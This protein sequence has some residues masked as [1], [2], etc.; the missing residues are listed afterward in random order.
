MLL[1]KCRSTIA[2]L[3][4]QHGSTLL[5][6]K[7]LALSRLLHKSL[8]QSETVSP[9]LVSLY[10]QLSTLRRRVL[11]RL[12]QG[13][14][15]SRSTLNDVVGAICAFCLATS[16]SPSDALQHFQHL[17][18]E[19]IRN[20]MC[21]EGDVRGNTLKAFRY[22]VHSL[23]STKA[24]LGRQLSEALRGLRNQP[25]IQDQA[26]LDL[27]E[28]DLATVQR[29]VPVEIRNFVPFIKH[30]DPTQLNAE[31]VITQWS[32]KAFEQYTEALTQH[33]RSL[34]KVSEALELR[35]SILE[36][37]LPIYVS[38]PS[39]SPSEILE[40]IRRIIGDQVNSFI[41]RDAGLLSD[42][43]LN[44]ESSV[45]GGS[46][47]EATTSR[48]LWDEGFV[49][50]PLGKGGSAFKQELRRRY[51]NT[52]DKLAGLLE[53]LETWIASVQ[54]TRTV[55]NQLRNDRW[56]DLIQEDEDDDEAGAVIAEKLQKEDPD[57]W[58]EG[59]N[60]ALRDALGTLQ[61]HVQE[62]AEALK[63]KGQRTQDSVI[64]LLR[65]IR[66]GRGRISS[67]F[68]GAD[69]ETLD[70]TVPHL[71]ILLANLVLMRLPI[72]RL[73]L[74]QSQLLADQHLWEGTPPLPA[75]PSLRAF[76]LLR[77]VCNIMSELG[78]DLWTPAAVD[79]VKV[80]VQEAIVSG[81]LVDLASS[82]P[83]GEGEASNSVAITDGNTS[84][85][86]ADAKLRVL[87]DYSY[88]QHALSPKRVLGSAFEN[89]LASL[90]SQL[91]VDGREAEVRAVEKRAKE[92]WTRT[93]LLFGLLS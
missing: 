89:I 21:I 50:M 19:N 11:R 52:S 88:L 77:D 55:I 71:H 82:N 74:N 90:R 85:T 75:Q 83:G 33:L 78:F 4:R 17:R 49:T 80:D 63:G 26:I 2:K 56:Q 39:H 35:K 31:S 51:L 6:A 67:A 25:I 29:W 18:L 64:F 61:Q 23:R 91:A 1:R 68:P 27:E 66:E 22:Y 69:L 3:L 44:I 20:Q 13:L 86:E 38:T 34:E 28:F 9:L 84:A 70:A 60:I 37:W 92:Y 16:S 32:K 45:D 30:T 46:L 43:S 59:Q 14:L 62:M 73:R 15:N 36:F 53:S 24:L 72:T 48:L 5:A 8:S 57:Q 93:S 65:L 10:E 81:R 42:V 7:V 41:L 58:I 12:D 54:A 87:Y 40:A 47:N 79:A 76:K